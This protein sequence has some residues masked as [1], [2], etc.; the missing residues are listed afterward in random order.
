[1]FDFATLK[2]K[3]IIGA[4][5]LVIIAGLIYGWNAKNKT[6]DK[7]KKDVVVEK[8][9][10]GS[11]TDTIKT[12]NIVD[13][14]DTDTSIKINNDTAEIKNQGTDIREKMNADIAKVEKK[15]SNVKSSDVLVIPKQSQDPTLTPVSDSVLKDNETSKIII[16]ALWET[17]CLGNATNANCV[18][19]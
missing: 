7:L 18:V 5:C 17:Y 9:I 3:L 10:N 6:I 1:M 16:D 2:I 19:N 8:V 14:V 11:L 12:D 13:K 15:Y 4:I